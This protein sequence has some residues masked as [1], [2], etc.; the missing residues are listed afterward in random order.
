MK[1]LVKIYG[2]TVMKIK[3]LK[4]KLDELNTQK[5][6]LEQKLY[7]KLIEA[8]TDKITI[9]G[10]TVYPRTD[11]YISLPN[12]PEAIDYVKKIGLDDLIRPY[13]PSQ[14]LTASIKEL[15][16]E[17]P[18]ILEEAKEILNYTEK[19]RVGIRFSKNA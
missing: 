18:L 14:T 16:K 8:E 4:L 13:I 17:D 5:Q 9:D 6:E 10:I 2:E 7:E 19:N 3:E 11:I 15:A 12:K 1:D